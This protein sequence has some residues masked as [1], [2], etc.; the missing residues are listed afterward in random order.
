MRGA[1]DLLKLSS[2]RPAYTAEAWLRHDGDERTPKEAAAKDNKICD[3]SGCIMHMEGGI[4]LALPS[5]LDAL[6]DDC[7]RADV[8]VTSIGLPRSVRRGCKSRLVID[9]F[10]LWRNGATSLT[11]PAGEASNPENWIRETTREMRGD[12]PWVRIPVARKYVK[13]EKVKPENQAP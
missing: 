9:R 13:A 12:R 10:D 4:V 5:S 8:I 11:I 7:T 2:A 6:R 3:V 1:D